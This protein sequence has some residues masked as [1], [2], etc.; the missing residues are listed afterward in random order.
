MT[1]DWLSGIHTVRQR[2][3]PRLCTGSYASSLD[4]EH[5]AAVYHGSCS[6]GTPETTTNLGYAILKNGGITTCSATRVGGYYIGETNFISSSSLSGIGYQYALRIA[7][8]E[9]CGQAL[10]NAKEFLNIWRMNY[11]GLNL[12]GDPIRNRLGRVAVVSYYAC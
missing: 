4:D 9:S 3:R 2:Q 12:Y 8:G 10:Y 1:M 6:N 5:P 7:N 11:F